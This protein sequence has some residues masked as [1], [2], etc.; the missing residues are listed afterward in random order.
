MIIYL[1]IALVLSFTVVKIML[2]LKAPCALSVVIG[3]VCFLILVGVGVFLIRGMDSPSPD[4]TII[5]QED[6]K[7]AAGL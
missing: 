7:K 1:G 3:I 5:T 6:L 2:W 4:S